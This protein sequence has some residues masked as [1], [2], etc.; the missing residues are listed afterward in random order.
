MG[1]YWFPSVLFFGMSFRFMSCCVANTSLDL[2]N[3]F[4]IKWQSVEHRPSVV[5]LVSDRPWFICDC[6]FNYPSAENYGRA[7]ARCSLIKKINQHWWETE[8]ETN[9][10]SR[11]LFMANDCGLRW[12][13]GSGRHLEIG[14]WMADWHATWRTTTIYGFHFLFNTTRGLRR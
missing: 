4:L 14:W 8:N 5:R 13:R 10:R 6:K 3:K 2:Y 1:F 11:P 9:K 7:P 12:F